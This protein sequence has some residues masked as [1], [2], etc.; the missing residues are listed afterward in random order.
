MHANTA[1]A[2]ALMATYGASGHP[3]FT[4]LAFAEHRSAAGIESHAPTDGQ[5]YWRYVAEHV[6]AISGDGLGTP[7]SP[8]LLT[9]DAELTACL[10]PLGAFTTHCAELVY[11]NASPY[12]GDRNAGLE[13]T[14][15]ADAYD[16]TG[17]LQDRHIQLL[18]TPGTNERIRFSLVA[19]PYVAVLCEISEAGVPDAMRCGLPALSLESVATARS[20]SRIPT[21]VR[22]LAMI[23]GHG[24]VRTG[25]LLDADKLESEQD[26]H[27]LA[28]AAFDHAFAKIDELRIRA[29]A[30]QPGAPS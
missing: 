10:R 28:E 3:F 12:D 5:R 4:P 13:L 6:M 2:D 15:L 26:V 16:Y 22:G 9:R 24:N 11:P 30:P 23:D 25:A 20:G 14:E 27:D 7:D 21:G 18:P 1:F 17:R 19:V 29:S 8:L